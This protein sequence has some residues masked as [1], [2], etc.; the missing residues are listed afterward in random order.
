[1][2]EFFVRVRALETYLKSKDPEF[3]G[4]YGTY[5]TALR[6]EAKDSSS[7]LQSLESDQWN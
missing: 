7:L 2:T 3:W 1:M 4:E 6:D 5:L